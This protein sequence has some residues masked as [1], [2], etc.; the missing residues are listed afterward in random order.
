MCAN[1]SGNQNWEDIGEL[2]YKPFHECQERYHQL[3]EQAQVTSKKRWTLQEDN[4]LI[5]LVVQNQR[6]R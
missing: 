5:Q 2:I 1:E 3:V 4:L 6:N